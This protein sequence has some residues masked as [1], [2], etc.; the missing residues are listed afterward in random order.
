MTIATYLDPNTWDIEERPRY[1][2]G[3]ERIGQKV[4]IR[5]QTLLGEWVYD[6]TQGLDYQGWSQKKPVDAVAIGDSIRVEIESVDEVVRVVPE[7]W[8][9]TFNA[10]TREVAC[11]GRIETYEGEIT[12]QAYPL[13]ARTLTGNSLPYVIVMLTGA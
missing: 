11:S 12:L 1:A 8:T 7:S 9:A 4:Q 5:V 10:V 3:L 6:R 2:T 13:G